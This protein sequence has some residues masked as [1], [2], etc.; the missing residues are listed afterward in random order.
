MMLAFDL[1]RVR[2]GDVAVEQVVDGLR[3]DGLAVARRAVDEHRVA[4]VDRR[5]RA[6]RAR[7]R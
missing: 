4:G 5:A 6:G 3:D 1:E 7:G 2:D